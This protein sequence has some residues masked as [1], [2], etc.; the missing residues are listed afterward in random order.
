MSASLLA[1]TLWLF[2]PP[3]AGDP[4]EDEP[5][6]EVEPPSEDEAKPEAGGPPP[7]EDPAEGLPR[8]ERYDPVLPYG[9]SPEETE[10]EYADETPPPPEL[11]YADEPPPPAELDY[12]QTRQRRA[13]EDE[14]IIRESDSRRDPGEE[15]FQGRVESPQRFALELKFGPYLPDVDRRSSGE[16]FGPYATIYGRTNDLGVT[17]GRPRQGLFSVL[18][19]E[20]Q[21]VHLGGPFSIG[22]TVGYFRD[23]ADALIATPVAEGE[24]VRAAADKAVFHVVP[25]TLLLGYRFELLADRVRVPLVP[26]ARG[27]V[28]YGFWVAKKGGKLTTNSAGEKSRGGS[29][30]WQANL[31]LM[32]RLDFFDRASSVDLDR[33]TGINHTYLFGEWQFSRL[34]NF[35][36][37]TAMSIGDD[38]FLVGLAVAF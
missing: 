36:A 7:V 30:G 26:Y 2:A 32:L 10:L 13:P 24:S 5:P 8:D 35:G 12:D 18:G 1:T 25:V 14:A 6:S 28:A 22:T 15:E 3:P 9:E 31:G 38:T 21:F 17:T 33:Q 11:E 34:N 16:G 27:G 37:D 29:F 23:S 19:F 20:W 4:S